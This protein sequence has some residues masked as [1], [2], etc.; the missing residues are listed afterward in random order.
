MQSTDPYFKDI[1]KLVGLL[2][3][4]IYNDQIEGAQRTIIIAFL[5]QYMLRQEI[6]TYY[7]ALA[8]NVFSKLCS[9]TS[10]EDNFKTKSLS[11]L[12]SQSEEDYYN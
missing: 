10:D 4:D 2:L 12:G 11:P 5:Q 3:Y 7:Q 9:L 6:V 1:T 8:Y